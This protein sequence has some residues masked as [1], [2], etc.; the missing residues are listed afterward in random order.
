MA[1]PTGLL[2]AE[3]ADAHEEDEL[4]AAEE[5]SGPCSPCGFRLSLW[6]KSRFHRSSP[7]WPAAS[8][9]QLL[10]AGL[11]RPFQLPFITSHEAHRKTR[12]AE[13]ALGFHCEDLLQHPA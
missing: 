3:K 11:S 5:V 8:H 6:G 2:A 10:L 12:P 7:G 13:I 1:L 9:S 4:Q